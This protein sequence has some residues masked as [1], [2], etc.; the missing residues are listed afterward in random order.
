MCPSVIEVVPCEDYTLALVFEDGKDGILDMKPMLDF[1]VFQRIKG[2]DDF[3]RVRIAFDTIQ[4]DCGVDLD[5]EY[6]YANRHDRG[7]Q[8]TMK[9][10]RRAPSSFRHAFSRNPEK[11]PGYRPSPV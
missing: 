7:S 8:R 6:V 1:S 11:R 9:V 4:W 2:L 5:P 3:K 10:L